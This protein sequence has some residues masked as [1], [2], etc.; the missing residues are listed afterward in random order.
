ML[1][2]FIEYN[3][4]NAKIIDFPTVTDTNF[5]ISSKKI[6]SSCSVKVQLFDTEENDPFILISQFNS[7]INFS[8]VKKILALNNSDIAELNDL[9]VPELDNSKTLELDNLKIL[10]LNDIETMNITGYKK[11]FIPPISI[12]GIKIIIDSSL[13]NK[14]FLF[15]RVSEKSFLKVPLKAIIDF[16]DDVV[17]EEIQ[18]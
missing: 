1:E 5:A 14:E 9:N 3:N 15:C 16:N 17:F 10:E 7:I 8:N 6:P 11:G 13:E 12:Y 18:D 2:D 4:I